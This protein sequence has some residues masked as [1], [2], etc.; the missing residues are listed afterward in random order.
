MIKDQNQCNI[1][2]IEVRIQWH[3]NVSP[4]LI[5]DLPSKDFGNTEVL[6]YRGAS[7]GLHDLLDS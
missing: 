7:Y 1:S 3:P 6:P 2:G 5:N 4:R